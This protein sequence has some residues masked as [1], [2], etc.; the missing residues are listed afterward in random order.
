MDRDI[1][2]KLRFSRLLFIQGYWSP[3]EVELSQYEH[4][5]LD[6]KRR[7]LTDVDVFGVKYDQLFTPHKVVGDCKTGKGVSD[8]NRLFW[9]RGVMAYFGADQAYFLRGKI[10]S[11][12]RAIAP[13]MGLH[14]LSEPELAA[15]EK[16]T[17]ADSYVLPLADIGIHQQISQAWGLRLPATQKPTQE[18]LAIKGVYSYLSYSYWYVE[19]FRN[20]LLLLG[21]FARI[22]QH[23]DPADPRHTLLAH[24]GAERFAYSLLDVAAHVQA[25]GASD[26]PKYSRVY[27]YGGPLA[28]KDKEQFFGLLSRVTGKQEALDPPFMPD[29]LEL[30]G[31]LVR[32]PGG[33]S[34]VLRH[35]AAVY[36]WCAHL[37]NP[38]L[39]PLGPGGENTA[40]IVL[41]KDVASTFT[42]ATGISEALFQAMWA[43]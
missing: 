7:S 4:G 11:H 24:V 3:I 29:V 30:V 28:L 9:L 41:A 31:R 32:N 35:L 33:A 5:R 16:K 36:L 21:S 18:D 19:P 2:L 25:Q 6:V 17:G 27:L 1:G 34:E 40:A 13:K 39:P 15:L 22:A 38:Y 8:V 23:L 12:A 20:L 26:I 42:K 43:L 37:G 10:D 14:V